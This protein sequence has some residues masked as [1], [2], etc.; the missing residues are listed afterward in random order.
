M[1]QSVPKDRDSCAESFVVVPRR[2]QYTSARGLE[3]G[4]PSP[5]NGSRS[6][7][8]EEAFEDEEVEAFAL[9][10]EGQVARQA[11]FGRVAGG[12]KLPAPLPC[13]P[14]TLAGGVQEGWEGH[15]ELIASHQGGIA[16]QSGR[17]R[18]PTITKNGDGL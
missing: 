16:G 14:M 10:G 9:E 6:G 18:E 7:G 15:L 1:L 11:V 3:Y 2:L 13:G 4:T 5:L 8:G 17:L 12:Q